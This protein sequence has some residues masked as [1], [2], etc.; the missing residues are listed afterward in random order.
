MRH[1]VLTLFMITAVGVI[2]IAEGRGPTPQTTTGPQVINLLKTDI[3]GAEG[4]VWNVSTVELASGAVAA[5]DSHLGVEVVYVL[6]GAGSLEVDGKPQVALKPG[7]V[8]QLDPKYNHV[9]RNTSLTQTLKVLLV[10]LIETGQPHLMLANRETRQ[11]KEARQQKECQLI[12]NGDL[13]QQK[14]NEQDSS[15]AKGLV[16]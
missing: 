11:Q 7:A 6:D 5:R 14:T 13:S 9:L 16:F 15:T 2:A 10:D 1:M 4:K 3:A 12:P 8:V